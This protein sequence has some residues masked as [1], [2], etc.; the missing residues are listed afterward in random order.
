MPIFAI[1]ISIL[2][3]IYT[4]IEIKIRKY[5]HLRG[6]K[7]LFFRFIQSIRYQYCGDREIGDT[8]YNINNVDNAV[9]GSAGLVPNAADG[10]AP[11]P[12]MRCAPK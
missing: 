10:I 6:I 7:T 4:N 5:E 1:L 12:I 11:N 8:I 9:C 2:A 3:R